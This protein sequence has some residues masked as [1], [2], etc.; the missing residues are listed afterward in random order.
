LIRQLAAC[1]E[2]QARTPMLVD[3]NTLVRDL[4][5][6]LKRVSG[7]DVE[8][9]LR[10]ASSPLN[11]EA[12]IEQVERLFVNVAGNGRARMP[13]GG[14]L[15]IELG[16]TVVDRHFAAKHPNVRLGLH[17][18]ITV[19]EVKR[20]ARADRGNPRRERPAPSA[21]GRV[22]PTVG[23]D[24]GTLQELVSECGGHLWMKVQRPGDMVVTIRLPLSSAPD[25]MAHRTVATRGGRVR[26]ARWFQS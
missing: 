17:A 9:Q 14:R 13:L 11:V 1:G 19:T 3:L 2:E 23:V 6:V 5:P 12:Q 16:T 26:S 4:E 8:I 25:Q 22:A 7:G 24:L 15:R 21:N 10:D 18:L 20:A